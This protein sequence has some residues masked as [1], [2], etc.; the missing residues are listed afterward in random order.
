MGGVKFEEEVWVDHNRRAELRQK[1][2]RDR[3]EEGSQVPVNER[4]KNQKAN[5]ITRNAIERKL[6]VEGGK[7]KVEV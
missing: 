6:E 1:A 4:G 5:P 7:F 2:N 3:E